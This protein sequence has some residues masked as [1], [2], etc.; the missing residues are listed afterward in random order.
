MRGAKPHPLRMTHV[1]MRSF[2][3]PSQT[4]EIG[5]KLVPVENETLKAMLTAK[6]GERTVA[7]A[8]LELAP[9]PDM[10]RQGARQGS[11]LG[12]AG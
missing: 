9:V 6:T 3:V 1:K 4:V 12:V 10:D 5:V 8:R 7:S 11:P 2:I